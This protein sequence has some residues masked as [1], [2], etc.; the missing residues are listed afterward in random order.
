MI[1]LL[2]DENSVKTLDSE[3]LNDFVVNDSEKK[4]LSVV[5]YSDDALLN[6]KCE[7]DENDINDEKTEMSE[8]DTDNEN[9]LIKVRYPLNTDASS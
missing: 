9:N 2:N 6:L 1:C 3:R 4:S 7:S 5:E 8:N